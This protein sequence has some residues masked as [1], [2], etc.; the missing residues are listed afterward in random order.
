MRQEKFPSA[1]D[2]VVPEQESCRTLGVEHRVVECS[3][4]VILY[5]DVL[6]YRRSASM[7]LLE[8]CMAITAWP[9]PPL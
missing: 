2:G 6:V 7:I 1:D 4:R 3:E 9:G 5:A 8:G